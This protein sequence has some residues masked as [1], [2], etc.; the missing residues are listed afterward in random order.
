MSTE[1][2]Q[3]VITTRLVRNTILPDLTGPEKSVL[4]YLS[5]LIGLGNYH[6]SEKTIAQVTRFS[7]RTVKGAI[8]ALAQKGYITT[9]VIYTHTG[10]RNLYKVHTG[11]L[12]GGGCKSAPMGKGKSAPMGGC[13]SAPI[14]DTS[15]DIYIDRDLTSNPTKAKQPTG[16]AGK[17]QATAGMPSP[18]C[19]AVASSF[20]VEPQAALASRRG[21]ISDR[22]WGRTNTYMVPPSAK[23][24]LS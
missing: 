17:Q 20:A 16:K 3:L 23:S 15:T 5:T 22:H 13:K 12:M 9:T 4:D 7:L 8:K 11:K 21:S 10:R 6:P 14:I 24:I 1:A 18:L 2:S 19:T